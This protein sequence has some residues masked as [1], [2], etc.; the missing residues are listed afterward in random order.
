MLSHTQGPV[1]HFLQTRVLLR[2]LHKRERTHH[3]L[4]WFIDTMNLMKHQME[5][6]S[7]LCYIVFCDCW[8]NI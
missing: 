8:S 6:T 7:S 1:A 5:L 4:G 3:V 2:D